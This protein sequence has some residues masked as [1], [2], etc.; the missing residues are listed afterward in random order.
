V[1]GSDNSSALRSQ[2]RSEDGQVTA[3]VI[4]IVV[5]LLMFAGLALD[6]GLALAAKV[7][8]IGEAQEAA[9]AGAQAIDLTAYRT[10]GT[11]RLRPDQ[12]RTRARSYLTATGDSGTIQA[13]DHTVTVIV[14]ARQRTQLLGL[15]GLGSLTVTGSG[16]AHPVLGIRNEDPNG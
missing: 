13:T 3:F 10:S 1:N 2:F 7:R 12:A 9:R 4:G 8:A 15:I 11:L 6:G 16:T 14:T 5:A